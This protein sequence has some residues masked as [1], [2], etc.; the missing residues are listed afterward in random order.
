MFKS[1]KPVHP[2][3][4]YLEIYNDLNFVAVALSNSIA[5]LY[6]KADT[7]FPV[8]TIKSSFVTENYEPTK[9]SW[10]IIKYRNDDLSDEGPVETREAAIHRVVE[11]LT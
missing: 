11:T 4:L 10:W 1:R 3:D 5:L 6:K 2:L 7:R 9:E 8:A